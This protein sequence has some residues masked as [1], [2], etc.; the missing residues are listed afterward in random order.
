MHT[1]TLGVDALSLKEFTG[2]RVEAIEG[3]PLALAGVLDAGLPK[4]VED[5]GGESL[6]DGGGLLRLVHGW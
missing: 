3:E 4:M 1:A 5:A 2:V 6:P